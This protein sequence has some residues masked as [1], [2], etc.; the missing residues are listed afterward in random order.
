MRLTR[1]YI[2][3]LRQRADTAAEVTLSGQAE[4]DR[5]DDLRDAYAALDLV[6]KAIDIFTAGEESTMSNSRSEVPVTDVS[7]KNVSVSAVHLVT[8]GDRVRVY[9]E[10]D[11]TWHLVHDEPRDLTSTEVSNIAN[12]GKWDPSMWAE[13]KKPDLGQCGWFTHDG[14][15]ECPSEA[16]T[17]VNG[18]P[19]CHRHVDMVVP[20]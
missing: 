17:E 2:E 11:R 13:R 16:V 20:E 12:I 6:A 1:R 8:E 7:V 5:L 18:R 19:L 3:E 14:Y 15:I 9:V 10:K 4:R